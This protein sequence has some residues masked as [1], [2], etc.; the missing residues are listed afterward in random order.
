MAAVL[1][2]PAV[3]LLC[4]ACVSQGGR[5]G[6]A[7]C[8]SATHMVHKRIF[9]RHDEQEGHVFSYVPSSRSHDRS[10]RIYTVALG[11]FEMARHRNRLLHQAGRLKRILL[12]STLTVTADS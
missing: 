2:L 10:I 5:K 3:Q 8:R 7:A 4:G 6:S 11:R 1:V 9:G 12:R